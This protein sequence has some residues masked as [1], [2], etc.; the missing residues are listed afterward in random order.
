MRIHSWLNTAGSLL[1]EYGGDLPFSIYLKQYF[2]AHKKHGSKD[3]KQIANLCYS[4]LRL[5]KAFQDT[6]PEKRMLIGQYLTN[7]IETDATELFP[8]EWKQSLSAPAGEK[9]AVLRRVQEWQMIFP[10]QGELSKEIDRELFTLS[11]LVQPNLF[12]RIRPHFKTIVHD[13]LKEADIDFKEIS[14]DAFALNNTTKVDQYINLDEEA[15]VQD[16]NSQ[17]VIRLLPTDVYKHQKVNAWDCCA[18][19]GGKSLLLYDNLNNVILTVSD[20]R[21]S[22]L[23]N[24]RNRFKRAGIEHYHSY[25]VDLSESKPSII[26]EPFDLVVCDAP[27]SGSGTWGRSPEQLLYFDSEKI[28]HYTELQKKISLNAARAIKKGGYFLYITCSVF[29]KENEEIVQFINENNELTLVSME[30]FKGYT[31]RADTLF[32][33]LFTL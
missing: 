12:L 33:A 10:L 18:A 31:M 23:H 25:M 21:E 2:A 5:G 16:Y 20:V 4:S 9:L 1:K 14:D 8:K 6:D 26:N 29:D 11:H 15:V 22:I 7:D 30:Y 27:C 28:G 24:L 13:K 17:Q 3:R 19:S 32:A